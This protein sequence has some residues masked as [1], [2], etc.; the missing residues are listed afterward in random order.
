[1]LPSTASWDEIAWIVMGL[2]WASM[3]LWGS[4]TAWGDG[5]YIYRHP[6]PDPQ[7]QTELLE[8]AYSDVLYELSSL[9]GAGLLTYLGVLRAALP[10]STAAPIVWF[11]IA[12]AWAFLYGLIKTCVS[13]RN[14]VIRRRFDARLNRKVE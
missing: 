14:R 1:M 5:L 6:H 11:Q 4:W 10:A 9:F 2:I 3:T 13:V 7:I 12:S 8:R